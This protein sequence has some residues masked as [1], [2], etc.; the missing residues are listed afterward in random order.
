MD[1]AGDMQEHVST[2]PADPKRPDLPDGSTKSCTDKTDGLESCPGTLSIHI[3]A[4]GNTNGLRTL[5]KL[6]ETPDLLA[7]DTESRKDNIKW[8]ESQT[9]ASDT[10]TYA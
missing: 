2:C 8:L 9:D 6:S 3:H 5:T 7:R 1:T 4:H 10:R